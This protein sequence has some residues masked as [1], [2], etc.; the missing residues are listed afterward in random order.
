MSYTHWTFIAPP[1]KMVPDP[2]LSS[3]GLVRQKSTGF[4]WLVVNTES[5]K[6]LIPLR[7]K[8]WT[9]QTSYPTDTWNW[10]T[11]PLSEIA[12]ILHCLPSDLVFCETATLT[13]RQ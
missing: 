10:S 13:V 6:W 3:G 12:R 9:G 1:E 8:D 11:I 7:E 5:K 4:Y 2:G